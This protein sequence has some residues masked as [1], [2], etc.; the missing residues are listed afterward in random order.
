MASDAE[1]NISLQPT[2][3]YNDKFF[4]P[5]GPSVYDP[6]DGYNMTPHAS[7][8]DGRSLHDQNHGSLYRSTTAHNDAV[9]GGSSHER[10]RTP[11]SPPA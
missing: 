7:L 9:T 3:P 1:D 2:T 4:Y 6:W 5:A 11:A 8:V 10:P